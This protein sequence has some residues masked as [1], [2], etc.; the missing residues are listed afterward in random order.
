M[1]YES[2]QYLV[3]KIVHSKIKDVIKDTKKAKKRKFLSIISP[4]VV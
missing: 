3:W 1:E 2:T 4:T